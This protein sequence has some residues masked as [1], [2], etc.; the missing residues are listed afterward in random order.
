VT[1]QQS[2]I[3]DVVAVE[4]GCVVQ[5]SVN[6]QLIAIDECVSGLLAVNAGDRVVVQKIDQL[7]LVTHRL[8]NANEPSPPL[9]SF[10]GEQWSLTSTETFTLKVGRAELTIAST[11]DVSIS[12]ADILTDATGINRLLGSRIELN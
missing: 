4:Q 12:G 10:D 8:P 7:F 5:V 3:A 9:L 2:F 1:D 6:D 11:G